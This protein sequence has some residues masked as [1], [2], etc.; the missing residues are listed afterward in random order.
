MQRSTDFND[1]LIVIV[2]GYDYRIYFCDM[3]K[4][5]AMNKMENANLN[6]KI[7][8]TDQG[9]KEKEI[10]IPYYEDQKYHRNQVIAK[11][12]YQKNKKNLKEQARDCYHQEGGKE[13]E[14]QHHFTK[15]FTIIVSDLLGKKIKK[16]VWRNR[17]RNI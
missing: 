2:K 14:K 8:L 17:Y 11:K 12:Y 6:E 7:G 1:V 3:C 10:Y 4:D 16:G 13:K 15:H 9:N 5:E